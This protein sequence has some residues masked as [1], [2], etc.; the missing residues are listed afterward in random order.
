MAV[1]PDYK[2]DASPETHKDIVNRTL[3]NPTRRPAPAA[4]AEVAKP[5]LQRG[6]FALSG[7]LVVDGKATAFLRETAG[8]RF[9]RVAQGE[10]IN[11]MVVSEIKTDRVRL[12]LGDES[13]DVILKVAV[14]PRTTVQP[15]VVAVPQGSGAALAGGAGAPG[16]P[17]TPQDVGSILAERR[18]A[19]REAEM[20][21]AARNAAAAGV[22]VPTP[23]NAPMRAVDP[24]SAATPP[25][26]AVDPQWQSVFQRYQQPR[27]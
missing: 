8:G 11:G 13:E 20:A 21:A 12:S 4:V 15:V 24:A 19:A 10:T 7:T 9:R 22:P 3:F 25:A 6:Q 27:R 16:Q 5:K 14:G 2:P 1:L 17:P 18:R 23:P 26:A